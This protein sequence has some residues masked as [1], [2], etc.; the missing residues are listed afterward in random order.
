MCQNE[1]QW[2]NHFVEQVVVL[3]W[4]LWAKLRVGGCVKQVFDGG[5]KKKPQSGLGHS[6]VANVQILRS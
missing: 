1:Q 4:E 6:K 5:K 2:K 3:D